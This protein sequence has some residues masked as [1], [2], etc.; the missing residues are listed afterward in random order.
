M[1]KT[2]DPNAPTPETDKEE[3]HVGNAYNDFVCTVSDI[4]MVVP[5][6]FARHIERQRDYEKQRGDFFE[7]K[8]KEARSVSSFALDQDFYE[9]YQRFCAEL[10]LCKAER[11][12]LRKVCDELRWLCNYA[13]RDCSRQAA[14]IES[15]SQLHHVKDKA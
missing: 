3:E 5:S 4:S 1:N 8:W 2:I 10:E 14:V 12:Q 15:Y 11:D 6:N 9:K 7:A 13:D